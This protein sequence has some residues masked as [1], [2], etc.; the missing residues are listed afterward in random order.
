VSPLPLQMISVA[1]GSKGNC[2]WI[3]TKE[4]GVLIDC[5]ISTKQIASRLSEV[6]GDVPPIDAVLLTHEHSDHVAASAILER[7]LIKMGRSP[8]FFAT[9]GTLRG[10]KPSWRPQ[11][12]RTVAQDAVVPVGHLT[13]SC[14]PVPHDAR[15][16]VAWTVTHGDHRAGVLTDLGHV[17]PALLDH[18]AALDL[19]LLEFNHD[20]IMLFEGDYPWGLKQR[21]RGKRGHL[22]NRQGA[23]LLR[24]VVDAGR[25]QHVILGHLSENNNRP[26]VARA[27]AERVIDGVTGI[28]LWVGRQASAVGPVTARQSRPTNEPEK[29]QLALF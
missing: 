2:T 8:T 9:E 29:G 13:A 22:S 16:P 7:R 5:G 18:V 23:K 10:M 4:H 14:Q 28:E 3:G 21:I 17:T 12:L 25:A 20:E 26:D 1:S 6:L 27:A 15:E 11:R 19:V 24:R